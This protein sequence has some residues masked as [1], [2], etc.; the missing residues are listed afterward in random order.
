MTDYP[1]TYYRI[2]ASDILKRDI[3]GY[4]TASSISDLNLAVNAPPPIPT[5]PPPPYPPLPPSRTV[6]VDFEGG[7]YKF[8]NSS[9]DHGSPIKLLFFPRGGVIIEAE[10]AVFDATDIPE[11]VTVP[12]I[13]FNVDTPTTTTTWPVSAALAKSSAYIP[14]D[15][16]LNALS[17]NAGDW[18]EILSNEYHSGANGQSGYEIKTKGEIAQISHIDTSLNHLYIYRG[19][20]D[21][22]S[23]TGGVYIASDGSTTTTSV[24]RVRKLN[25]GEK[26]EVRGGLFLGTNHGNS[27]DD[28]QPSSPRGIQFNGIV[29]GRVIGAE[30]RGFG[31]FVGSA[32][33]CI[34]MM[35]SGCHFIGRDYAVSSN[36]GVTQSKWFDGFLFQ[37][38][39]GV[40]FTGNV[41]R[42][43]RHPID[44]QSDNS[45]GNGYGDM[46]ICRN[47]D[48]TGNTWEDSESAYL[49]CCENV[50]F[51]GNVAIRSG[52]FGCRGKHMSFTGNRVYASITEWAFRAGGATNAN[53][54]LPTS[55]GHINS[56]GN[57]VEGPTGGWRIDADC[58]S[59]SSEGDTFVVSV[60]DGYEF[61]NQ[62]NGPI[63]IANCTLDFSARAHTID[64]QFC[65]INI[66]NQN[67]QRL[68]LEAVNIS[69][70]IIKGAYNGIV[71]EGTQT[72]TTPA[73]NIAIRGI[74]FIS[75]ENHDVH[76]GAFQ[77]HAGFYGD[78]NVI[79]DCQ[80]SA[81]LT[82]PAV[83]LD[84]GN[85]FG[86]APAVYDNSYVDYRS[87]LI[88]T[89]LINTSADL[90]NLQ[91]MNYRMGDRVRNTNSAVGSFNEYVC[92]SD[93]TGGTLGTL[94]ASG[95]IAAAS[96]TLT[97][98]TAIPAAV[99][100][101]ATVV[102]AGPSG[103]D[104]VAN[105]TAVSTDKKTLTLATAASVSVMNT[106]VKVSR[107]RTGTYTA[108]TNTL[109]LNISTSL[110]SRG[111]VLKIP[112]AGPSGTDLIGYV[113]HIAADNKTITLV[114]PPAG[115]T[116]VNVSN[117][118]I[119]YIAP[120]WKGLSAIP[121]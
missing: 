47:I 2:S 63:T 94:T 109:V 102:G 98:T 95:A 101:T 9:V 32:T 97:L 117:A 77:G 50:N 21:D 45:A 51:T 73:G 7:Y 36:Q 113:D 82:A 79:S 93:G 100:M 75:S 54:T 3:D 115:I 83:Y 111:Q 89:G 76:V 25:T 71:I 46:I 34:D 106:L 40:N 42:G 8:N 55:C 5:P 62:N 78:S 68:K 10:G 114:P 41:G 20:A 103:A 19:L 29:G 104:L 58:D 59:F 12:L 66:L 116:T 96:T 112:S 48:V 88:Y 80:M 23:L 13:S 28:D 18:I 108:A 85:Y 74:N 90:P 65:G 70:C 6:V 43:L 105:I 22:Y 119:S 26:C 31:R 87:S 17:L 49:H 107:V 121:S 57:Y 99:N 120:V 1:I 33:Q 24:V 4:V 30:F 84:P 38:C 86:R 92:T 15:T 35:V 56:S 52:G 118:T 64:T 39:Q 69:G 81:S 44:V 72:Y 110:V 37:S 91:G 16:S 53:Y 60:G 67:N 61:R 11:T 14:V 27:Q